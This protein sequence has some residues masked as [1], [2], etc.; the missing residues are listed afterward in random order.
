MVMVMAK[1]KTVAQAQNLC[2]FMD[3]PSLQFLPCR[4]SFIIP[5]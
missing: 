2:C 1:A 5:S 3:V 4:F